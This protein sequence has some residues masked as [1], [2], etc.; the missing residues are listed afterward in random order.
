MPCYKTT[1]MS[2]AWQELRW[3][4]AGFPGEEPLQHILQWKTSPRNRFPKKLNLFLS[5]LRTYKEQLHHKNK[6]PG[7]ETLYT[8]MLCFRSPRCHSDRTHHDRTL[9]YSSGSLLK[10]SDVHKL[11]ADSRNQ[12]IFKELKIVHQGIFSPLHNKLLIIMKY[13]P[14][15]DIP[16]KI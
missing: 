15:H 8:S 12:R 5:A 4:G 11:I 2:Q 7:A 9:R 16:E 14:W 1:W 3:I 10:H 13:Y 6:S